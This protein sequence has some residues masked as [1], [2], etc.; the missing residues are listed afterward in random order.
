MDLLQDK[1]NDAYDCPFAW[2]HIVYT[3]A[4]TR[5]VRSSC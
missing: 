1:L 5:T 3:Y 2:K 4:D